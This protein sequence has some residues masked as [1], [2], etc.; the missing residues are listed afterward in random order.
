MTTKTTLSVKLYHYIRHYYLGLHF[1]SMCLPTLLTIIIKYHNEFSN[2]RV[3]FCL[4]TVNFL[5]EHMFKTTGFYKS[6]PSLIYNY[7][8]VSLRDVPVSQY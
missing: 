6:S 1:L 3:N 2:T 7:L 8:S 5:F 4:P